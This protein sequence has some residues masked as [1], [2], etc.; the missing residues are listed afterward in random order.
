MEFEA[1]IDAW[2]VWVGVALVSIAV[3]GIALSIP[4]QPPPDAD[5]VAGTLDRVAA[6]GYDASATISHDATSIRLGSERIGMRNDG[7]TDE[8]RI[9]FGT[10]VTLSRVNATQSEQTALE[11]VIAGERVL[12]SELESVLEP[13]VRETTY[14][15]GEWVSVE[16]PLRARAVSVGGERIVLMNI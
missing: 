10:V 8:A 14:R 7:G 15:T 12:D 2:Y 3:A 6:S 1:P 13:A 5:G 11:G 16:G 4:A 9:A